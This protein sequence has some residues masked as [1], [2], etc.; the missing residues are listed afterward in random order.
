MGAPDELNTT[1]IWERF[2]ESLGRESGTVTSGTR[3]LLQLGYGWNYV[4]SDDFETGTL[5]RQRLFQ[6][7]ECGH[8]GYSDCALRV[9]QDDFKKR[10]ISYACNDAADCP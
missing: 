9:V 3:I 5:M 7:E 4:H 10:G 8:N 2:M 6:G 1:S